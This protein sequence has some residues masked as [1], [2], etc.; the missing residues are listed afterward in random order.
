MGKTKQKKHNYKNF[1]AEA[2]A[3]REA[4]EREMVKDERHKYPAI[5]RVDRSKLRA[6][7]GESSGDDDSSVDSSKRA[8]RIE[9][10]LMHGA[11][12]FH[13]AVSTT[14]GDLVAETHAMFDKNKPKVLTRTEEQD[15]MVTAAREEARRASM[16]FLDADQVSS[17]IASTPGAYTPVAHSDSDDDSASSDGAE[18]DE[19]PAPAP[20]GESSQDAKPDARAAP[21]IS[22][23]PPANFDGLPASV[24]AAAGATGSQVVYEEDKARGR[25]SMAGYTRTIV[26][27]DM[28]PKARATRSDQA[29][30][31]TSPLGA[32]AAAAPANVEPGRNRLLAASASAP[33]LIRHSTRDLLRLA[34]TASRIHKVGRRHRHDVAAS[35]S[36][37]VRLLSFHNPG[38]FAD[39]GP[40]GSMLRHVMRSGAMDTDTK[41]RRKKP[42]LT[43]LVTSEEPTDSTYKLL[44]PKQKL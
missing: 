14:T 15:L 21:M 8:A 38:V 3:D 37:G 6:E 17:I 22:L 30:P 24:L 43:H 11:A 23:P 16:A 13:R 34:R 42:T 26:R 4:E 31:T 28:T 7:D 33:S 1:L 5:E 9:P 18:G 20:P 35:T 41:H 40:E 36:A 44:T 10:P 39:M 27:S 19:A 25:N 2:A 29:R 12:S 32:G